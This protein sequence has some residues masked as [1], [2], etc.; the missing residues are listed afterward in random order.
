MGDLLRKKKKMLAVPL[1]HGILVV[2]HEHK[3]QGKTVN[4]YLK[5]G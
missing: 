5:N 3:E 1:K 2:V 4:N